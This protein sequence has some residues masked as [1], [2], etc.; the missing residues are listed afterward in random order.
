MKSDH[1][2]R[3]FLHNRKVQVATGKLAGRHSRLNGKRSRKIKKGSKQGMG[4]KKNISRQIYKLQ[5]LL[6]KMSTVHVNTDSEFSS[7]SHK[8]ISMS[9]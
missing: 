7:A 3:Q 8:R 2:E 5:S 4:Q 1:H 6:V 9:V